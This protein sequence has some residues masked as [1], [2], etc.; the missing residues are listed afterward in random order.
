MTYNVLILGINGFIGSGLV[1]HILSKTDWHIHGMDLDDHKLTE[2][3]NHPRLHFSKGDILVEKQWIED[4]I[5]QCDVVLPLVAIATPAT[6][7]QNPLRVFE[8]DFEANLAI[9]RLCVKYGKR[10]I[11]PSTSEVYGMSQDAEFDEEITHFVLGPTQ[12]QR[13]IY[14]CSKQLLDRVIYAYGER[15][16][17]FRPFNWIG[18]K[19]DDILNPKPGGSRVVTQFIG[20]ILRG[21]SIQLVDGGKQQRSFTDIDDAI[22]AL[23]LIIENKNNCAEKGIFNIGNPANNISIRTLAEL[24]IEQ[25]KTY[26][27]YAEKAA[28]TQLID[29][30]A[31]DY[32]GKGYQD[33]GARV[34]SIKRAN[35][36]LGWEPKVGMEATLKK[37]L[38]F[39]L[40]TTSVEKGVTA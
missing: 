36:H 5:K 23:L 15:Y 4:H 8:L 21:D 22:S 25:I 24:L 20:N 29:V 1:D 18:A 28:K 2:F 31:D 16:T 32:Y 27:D 7:V 34:P 12:K 35:T 9:I 6:Y 38:D 14:S 26:P 40:S 39:H 30:H 37:I 10:V 3:L 33:V 11:F 13:W 19:Q 17:L